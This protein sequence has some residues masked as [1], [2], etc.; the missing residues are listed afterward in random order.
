MRVISDSGKCNL[1][2]SS[3]FQEIRYYE[4]FYEDQRPQNRT[5]ILLE[6]LMD[7][8]ENSIRLSGSEIFTTRRLSN[9]ISGPE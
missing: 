9:V 4:M 3:L 7:F 8:D 5:F 2:L 6:T 1:K